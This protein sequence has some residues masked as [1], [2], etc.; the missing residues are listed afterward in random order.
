M[1]GRTSHHRFT[2]RADGDLAVGS[3]GVA[4]R[5]MALVDLP[6]TWL[7][8]VHG[9]EVVT[10]T[11][12]GEHAG[13]E[14]DAA[15]TAVPGAVLAVQAADCAPVALLADGVVGVAHAGWR[16]LVAGVLPAAVAAMRAIGAGEVRAL[17][18][19][20]VHPG[21]Y[22]LGEPALGEVEALLGPS[23]VSR[24][25]G[26]APALDLPAAVSA[27]LAG[28]GVA[29]DPGGTTCTACAPDTAWSHRARREAGRQAALAWLT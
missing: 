16:V 6:W 2:T 28:V 15:V 22:E 19:P 7:H 17:L 3:D 8:Q 14:A 25:T 1:P 21:C 4:A 9:A 27:S 18:G 23:V 5:R 20:C 10:V 13:A 11:R 24:T 29:L 26:G 12:P